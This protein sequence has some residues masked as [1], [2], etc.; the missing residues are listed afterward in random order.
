ML[1]DAVRIVADWLNDATYGV[2]AAL[3]SVPADGDVADAASVTVYDE[4]RD[5]EIARQQIPDLLPA[6]IVSTTATPTDMDRP[7]VRPYPSDASVEIGIRYATQRAATDRATTDAD[8][9]RRAVMRSL[10]QLFTTAAGEAA[11]VRNQVQL[12]DWRSARVELYQSNEDTTVTC[13]IVCA[14]TA[15]DLWTA[16]A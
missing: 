8:Q 15:R 13:A 6:L 16:D 10:R 7:A 9:V 14:F 1:T 11:R 5:P 12:Y 2:N 4:T 3:A